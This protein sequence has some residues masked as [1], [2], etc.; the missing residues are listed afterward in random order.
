MKPVCSKM[1][2]QK[3]SFLGLEKGFF[4]LNNEK[5]KILKLKVKNLTPNDI[6][7]SAIET[8]YKKEANEVW[9]Y[10]EIKH[11]TTSTLWSTLLPNT[12]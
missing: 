3:Q 7:T 6:M 11:F 10:K 5:I 12:L 8:I 4:N 9:N 1:Q 2:T